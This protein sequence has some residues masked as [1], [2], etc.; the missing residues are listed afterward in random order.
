MKEKKARIEVRLT[1]RD[2]QKIE[3][4]A[5]RCGVSVSEFIR[6]SALGFVPREVQPDVFY[7]LYGKLCDLCNQ[8]EFNYSKET[9]QELIALITEI[10]EAL[11]LPGKAAIP[12]RP[13]A[14]G[15]SKAD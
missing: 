15:Q 5:C 3:R 2:K 4:N 14:S 12:W 11:L 10:R 6:Q 1:Q 9:E 7:V 13:Q 8:T